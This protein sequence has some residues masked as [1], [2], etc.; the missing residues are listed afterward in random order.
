MVSS[1]VSGVGVG[2]V[3]SSKKGSVSSFGAGGGVVG[4]TSS[5]MRGSWGAR[6][7]GGVA[8]SRA[9]SGLCTFLGGEV[10]GTR[11]TR[12]FAFDKAS[13]TGTGF[14]CGAGLAMGSSRTA[15]FPKRS[16]FTGL[17]DLS[18]MEKSAT[19]CA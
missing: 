2:K 18:R 10:S 3:A 5:K 8:T 17:A 11:C 13:V 9:G 19:T 1:I 7:S 14:A 4:A 12:G 15:G 16:I 6:I